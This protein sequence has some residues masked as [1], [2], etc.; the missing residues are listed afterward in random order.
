MPQQG[1]PILALF[2][3]CWLLAEAEGRQRQ[4]LV[5]PSTVIPVYSTCTRAAPLTFF[6]AQWQWLMPSSENSNPKPPS[7]HSGG[8]CWSRVLNCPT[9]RQHSQE[10]PLRPRVGGQPCGSSE[11][12]FHGKRA[13]LVW[14]VPGL[15][16]QT[17][18]RCCSGRGNPEPGC[19]EER[20]FRHVTASSGRGDAHPA[21]AETTGRGIS[22]GCS[23]F[24]PYTFCWLRPQSHWL[25]QG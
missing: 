22:R 24:L 15:E 6:T 11:S 12:P 14:H 13:K 7:P 10:D 8:M 18:H 5:W 23:C 20:C 4:T 2:P 21:A 25:C 1:C 3:G 19:G 17:V 16:A 9:A